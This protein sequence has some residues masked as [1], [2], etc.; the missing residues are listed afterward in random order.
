MEQQPPGSAGQP[1]EQMLLLR[2]GDRARTVPRSMHKRF[3]LRG[4]YEERK[5]ASGE[6]RRA[7]SRASSE[8]WRA[9]RPH[10]I[11][12]AACLLAFECDR[13][14]ELLRH[15]EAARDAEARRA[16]SGGAAV[17]GDPVSVGRTRAGSEPYLRKRPREALIGDGANGSP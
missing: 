17:A 2:M 13:R 10:D 14:A 9:P 15:E 12:D 7:E 5:R 3:G 6:S 4:D 8:Q 1:F 16:P 11:A